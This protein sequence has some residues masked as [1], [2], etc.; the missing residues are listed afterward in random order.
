MLAGVPP[1][2]T[3]NSITFLH[4][5]WTSNVAAIVKEIQ[6][7]CIPYLHPKNTIKH[8]NLMSVVCALTL[9]PTSD[10]NRQETCLVRQKLLYFYSSSHKQR[11]RRSL[12]KKNFIEFG[13]PSYWNEFLCLL[14][15]AKS[16]AFKLLQDLPQISPDHQFCK[17]KRTRF[18]FIYSSV[19]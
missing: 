7:N 12:H 9:T 2:T 11:L 10:K 19:S 15:F 3:K 6:L 18:I 13:R 5:R 4:L 16:V 17:N 8:L 14:V 1:S